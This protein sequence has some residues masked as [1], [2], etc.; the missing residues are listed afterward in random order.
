MSDAVPRHLI[1]VVIGNPYCR[2]AAAA[3]PI[4]GPRRQGA[5]QVF[6]KRTPPRPAPGEQAQGRPIQ[7]HAHS[8]RRKSRWGGRP[9]RP[10]GLLPC[11][12]PGQGLGFRFN[13]GDGA[14]GMMALGQGDVFDDIQVADP[15]AAVENPARAR[16]PPQNIVRRG[17]LPVGSMKS[18]RPRSGSGPRAAS[19]RGNCSLPGS[20]R[21]GSISPAR[22]CS[23]SSSARPAPR[24]ITW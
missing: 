17:G 13:L 22:N 24:L 20:T 11:R 21:T 14:P 6:G 23:V 10:R 16:A 15:A 5:R 4:A 2:S 19:A 1:P 12:V 18:T 7:A 9:A 3:A 8:A